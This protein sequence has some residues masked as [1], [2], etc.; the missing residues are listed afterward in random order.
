MPPHRIA[1]GSC[2][3]QDSK[4]AFWPIIES[5][6]PTAFVWGGDA[7]YADYKTD[8]VWSKFPPSSENVCGTP[9]RLEQ[10]YKKQLLQPAYQSLLESNVT[11]FGT[12]DD[13]D[14][15]CNNADRTFEHRH[16]SAIEYVKFLQAPYDSAMFRRA[17]AGHGVYGVKVFDFARSFGDQEIHER[18]AGVDPDAAVDSISPPVYSNQSVAVFVLDVRS[19]KTPWKTGAAA[20]RPDFEGDFLGERQWEWFETAIQRSQASVNVVV[21]GLQVHANKF[22]NGNVAEAWG[23]YPRAQQRLFDAI[24]Q[25]GVQSPILISGD[26]HMNQLSRKDCVRNTSRNHQVS[27]RPLIEMT[28]SGMTHSWGSIASPSL[29]QPNLEVSWVTWYHTE[30]LRLLMH[31]LHWFCPWTEIM[32]TSAIEKWEPSSTTGLQY[33][34]DKNF[35]ELEFDWDERAV[36]MR[37]IGEN[38]NAPPLLSARFGMDELSGFSS[39][40]NRHF[41]SDTDF[42]QASKLHQP[43]VDREWICVN[44]RGQEN[45]LSHVAGYVATGFAMTVLVPFPFFLPCVVLLM[46]FYRFFVSSRSP[47]LL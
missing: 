26:V 10:L 42:Q 31:S 3:D 29:Q 30:V 14:Y 16:E 1:F 37:T 7:I 28:T 38:A 19:N 12:F 22:P 32:K 27:P 34:L 43:F 9:A 45:N 36:V 33:N 20:Y 13:H 46:I 23:K 40:S 17:R 2:N 47:T 25:D 24:L 35:G 21:T 41:L 5:R 6:K 18:E 8:V 15:G 44:H 11:V 39:T 4:N